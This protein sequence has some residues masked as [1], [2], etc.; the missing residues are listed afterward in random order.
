MPTR[1]AA[2]LSLIAFAV[3]LFTGGWQAG[4]TFSTTVLRSLGALAGTFAV[5]LIIGH[6]AKKM[7]DE[8]LDGGAAAQV[9]K[10]KVNPKPPGGR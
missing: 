6:M 1:L 5:G 8:N 7:L 9:E 3:C 10:T 4:N 2:I